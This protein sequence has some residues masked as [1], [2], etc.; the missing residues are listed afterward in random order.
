[1]V[2]PAEI[3]TR[4]TESL[5]GA[6]VEVFDLTGGGDHYRVLVVAPGF[7]NQEAVDRHRMVYSLFKDVLGGEL[8]ALSMETHTPREWDRTRAKNRGENG[9]RL[10]RL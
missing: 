2:S 10:P 5:S 6:Q 1:M 3:E 9:S 8:H 4:I 7:E